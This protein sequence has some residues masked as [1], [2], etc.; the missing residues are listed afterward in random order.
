MADGLFLRS[1]EDMD[2]REDRQVL[3][4]DDYLV[5]VESYDFKKDAPDQYSETGKRDYYIF[6]LRP[7]SFAD[8]TELED[9]DGNAVEDDKL[10]F[11]FID[12]A[13]TGFGPSGPSRARKFFAAALGVPATGEIRVSS[14]AD[15]KG[16]EL[17]ASTTISK[18]GKNNKVVDFR[19]HKTTRRRSRT[20]SE[21]A[22]VAAQT[23]DAQDTADADPF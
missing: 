8:G 23:E 19:T 3:P 13:R 20:E 22:P 12:P 2:A 15:L 18:D 7:V 1:Q 17:I 10:L 9:V 16:K 11:A 6:K 4:E 5:R 14:M 21:P